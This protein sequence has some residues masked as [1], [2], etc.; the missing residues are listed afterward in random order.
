MADQRAYLEV[1]LPN[2]VAVAIMS[3]I[4]MMLLGLGIAQYQ[5]W[6]GA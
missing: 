6:R 4:G 2:F 5:K 1:N 3:Y